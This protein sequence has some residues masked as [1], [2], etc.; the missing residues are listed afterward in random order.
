M[1][2]G[3]KVEYRQIWASNGAGTDPSYHW[4]GGWTVVVDPSPYNARCVLIE[5]E[6]HSL[7]HIQVNASP[8]DLRGVK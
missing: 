4:T 1:K 8:S 2:P 5:G 3:T 6:S 7:G